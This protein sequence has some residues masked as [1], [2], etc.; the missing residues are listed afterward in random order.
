MKRILAIAREPYNS[1]KNQE[2]L[3]LLM[4]YGSYGFEVSLVLMGEA[5]ELLSQSRPISDDAEKQMAKMIAGLEMYDVDPLYVEANAL[6]LIKP[7]VD[8]SLEFEP[9]DRNA[10]KRLMSSADEVLIL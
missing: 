10:I 6:K 5:V 1:I 9:V 3:E 2:Q 4:V 8:P 7:D